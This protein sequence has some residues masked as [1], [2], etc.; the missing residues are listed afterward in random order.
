MKYEK[1]FTKKSRDDPRDMYKTLVNSGIKYCI[2]LIEVVF[3][4][5][6]HPSSKSGFSDG[7][8]VTATKKN[9][10]G[11]L[12]ILCLDTGSIWYIVYIYPPE[13]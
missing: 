7:S 10:E 3:L 6:I 9:F 8:P 1:Y 5:H 12:W 4:K 2:Y 13:V 11:E